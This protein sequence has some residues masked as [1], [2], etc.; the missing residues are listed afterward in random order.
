M[1]KSIRKLIKKSISLIPLLCLI[2]NV[3]GQNYVDIARFYYSGSPLNNFDKSDSSTHLK[4]LGLDV[5]GPLVINPSHAVLTGLIY[6]RIQTKLFETGPTETITSVSLK[7]GLSKTHSDNWSGT[8]LLIPKLASDFAHVTW[9][10]FQ[11]GAIV[12]MKYKK[13][14]NLSYKL[15]VYYNA[16]F[17]GPFFA[18]LIGLYYLSPAKKFEANLT[19]PFLV[20]INYN[21]HD[22]LNIGM[23]F[24]AQLRSYR[25]TE[26]PNS[27][28]G[29]YVEKTTNE[30]FGYLKFNLS[31]SLSIQTK[32]GYTLGRSYRVYDEN[33]K[34]TFATILIKVGDNRQQ[35]NTD[36]SDGFLFQAALLYRII[37]EK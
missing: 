6:E 35:L 29:G 9:D 23:N 3:F 10:D 32:V 22:R 8:Y 12:L 37:Q 21:L 16:E 28:N 34:I 15:G 11:L 13:R 33:D 24:S 18:P 30:L 17:F 2:T 31:Q 7:M 20:D 36:F 25:L 27:N 1:E 26:I 5:T 14:E 4:E 19:L